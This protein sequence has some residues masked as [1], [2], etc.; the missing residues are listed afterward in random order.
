MSLTAEQHTS[1]AKSYEEAAADIS[2][3]AERR[4]EFARKAEWFRQLARLEAKRELSAAAS[5]PVSVPAPEKENKTFGMKHAL[6]G[7]WLI[8]GVLYLAGTVLF[9]DAVSLVGQEERVPPSDQSTI[10]ASKQPQPTK[11]DPI[12]EQSPQPQPKAAAAPD[13]KHAISPDQPA[14]EP[15]LTPEATNPVQTGAPVSTVEPPKGAEI[16]Q[17]PRPA[18][19]PKVTRKLQSAASIR[20]GPTM[21]SE[22]IGTA[23]AGAEL[24]ITAYEGDWV[25]FVDPRSGNT[26]W[27]HSKSIESERAG[28]TVIAAT[29]PVEELHQLE[30]AKPKLEKSRKPRAKTNGVSKRQR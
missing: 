18:D 24:Q 19:Q 7:L 13:R 23:A 28:R 12:A 21:E 1:I 26:G 16:A 14:S 22:I 6:V 9:S 10:T 27:L 2:I 4:A 17:L 5:E 8:G 25:K 29:D 11:A 20:S 15:P 3:P 30:V